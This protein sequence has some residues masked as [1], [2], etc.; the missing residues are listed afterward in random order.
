MN[1]P[2]EVPTSKLEARADSGLAV[3]PAARRQPEAWTMWQN[4]LRLDS[5]PDVAHAFIREASEY[6]GL[7]PE[8]V[9]PRMQ[10]G[11]QLLADEWR[12]MHIDPRREEDLLR[13]Y[14]QNTVEAFELLHY[15]ACGD[16]FVNYVPAL[17]ISRSR[18][19]RRYLDYGSGIGSGAILFAR[20]GFDLTLADI[21]G[22]LLDFARW[23]FA[24]RGLTGTFIDLKSQDL[25]ARDFDIITAFDVL[26][27]TNNPLEII[28]KLRQRLCIRGL[29]AI[30]TP[31]EHDADRPMH[32]FHD[33]TI[34]RRFRA[35]GFSYRYEV[36]APIT[37]L[38]KVAN[39][40]W[41]RC[42][43]A[44]Y[45]GHL[46]WLTRKLNTSRLRRLLRQAE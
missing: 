3:P 12:Q 6:F 25:P 46:Y 32:I 5:E 2:T 30:N 43:W 24:R 35:M 11:T 42:F 26:E 8:T 14:N 19:G 1:R 34:S 23:R 33:E 29:L 44:Y 9:W 40:L 45:D 38:E 22:P 36:K 31:F 4:A 13:F 17:E 21:S 18:S 15:N 10:Q 16:A 28:R 37:V 27:H 41:R 7:P 39:P 20:H